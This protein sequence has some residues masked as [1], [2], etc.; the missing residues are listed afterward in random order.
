[1]TDS[2]LNY[3]VASARHG[4]FTAAAE[5]VGVTQSAIT[6]SIADLERQL[7]FTIFHRTARGIILTEDGRSFVER[8]S[9]L[10]EE[11]RNLLQGSSRQNDA[12]AGILRIGVCPSSLEWHLA[13]PI[14]K[15]LIRHPSIRFDLSGSNFERMAQNLRSGAVDVVVGFDEAFREHPE[16]KRERLGAPRTVMFA[17]KDHPILQLASPTTKDVAQYEFVSPSESRPYGTKIRNYYES[18]GIESQSRI[19]T[20]DNFPIVMRIVANSNALSMAAEQYANTPSFSK[21]FSI[22]PI[23]GKPISLDYLC[24]AVRARWEIK[25]AV[26]AFIKACQASISK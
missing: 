22:V 4:S 25:P 12:F 6:K 20:I 14:T 11:S 5:A 16:F 19:H 1:M 23:R 8:A 7:G 9:R 2:R 10:L 17:R 3:V 26:R 24:C 18:Q 15:L 13:E 21:R